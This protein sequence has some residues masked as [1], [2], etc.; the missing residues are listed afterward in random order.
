MTV[1]S[2]YHRNGG[3]SDHAGRRFGPARVKHILHG[4]LAML[5]TAALAFVPCVLA[6]PGD[7]SEE[8]VVRESFPPAE[9]GYVTAASNSRLE[10]RVN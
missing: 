1:K 8:P 3:P 10:L 2:L 4:G 9:E 7:P 6:E 5:L